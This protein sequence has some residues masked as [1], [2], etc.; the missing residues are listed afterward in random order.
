VLLDP[1]VCYR[2]LRTRDRRFDGRFFTAVRTTGIYCRPICPART[3]RREN[4]LFVACAAAAEEAGY[5]PCRRCRPESAPGTPAWLGT[6]ATVTR[7]LRLIAEGALDEAG[8]GALAARLGLGERQLRRLFAQHLGAGPLAIARTR[9]AHFA[10]QLLAQTDWPIA[11]VAL[12]AGF[13]SL[14]RF[15]E[16]M[17]ETFHRSPRELRAARRGGSPERGPAI[18]LPYRAPFDRAGVFAYLAARA[19]PGVEIVTAERIAR[20]LRIAGEPLVVEVGVADGTDALVLCAHGT[21]AIPWLA[22]AER[23]RAV[24]DL[25]ADPGEIGR[26]LASDPVLRMRVRGCPGVRVPGAWDPF[27]IAVR[28]ALG[29]QI[30]VAGATL[31]AGRLA[32]RFGDPLPDAL[33]RPGGPSR[34]FPE[35]DALADAPLEEIGLTRQRAGALRALARAVAKG[36]LDLSARRRHRR[37]ARGAARVARHRA[38]DRRA[39]ADACARRSRRV[40]GR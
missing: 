40:S 9:R 18:R 12:A 4:C 29:Q 8:V 15:N 34:V 3:P 25:A 37:R 10:A 14:R 39:R 24:F 22:L 21:G 30:T 2:A 33:V 26:Q 20:A 32:E 36:E 16:V 23:A 27:E 38:V 31:L 5:R 13:A 11:R 28:I 7:G 35:P 19:V 17:R 1:D 6:S